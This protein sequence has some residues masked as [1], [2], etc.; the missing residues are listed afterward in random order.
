MGLDDDYAQ[1]ADEAQNITGELMERKSG[2]TGQP[3]YVKA[4]PHVMGG[5]LCIGETRVPIGA[6]V[7]FAERGVPA[8]TI[9]GKH[10]PWL[11]LAEVEWA[12]EYHAKY[13]GTVR[14]SVETG[15]GWT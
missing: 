6:V 1:W 2:V 13:G 7:A 12:L 15:T 8:E 11:T 5:K 3:P 4:T 14:D 9:A 10:Y